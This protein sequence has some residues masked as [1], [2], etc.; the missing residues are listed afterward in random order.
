MN[1][2]ATDYLTNEHQVISAMLGVLEKIAG[3]IKDGQRPPLDDLEKIFD[4]FKTYADAGHHAKEEDILF[5]AL[6]KL[7]VLPGGP[8]CTYFFETVRMRPSAAKMLEC[9]NTEMGLPSEKIVDYSGMLIG[10][11]IQFGNP[12]NPVLEEHLLGRKHMERL[13]FELDQHKKNPN[14]PTKDILF[15]IYSYIDL[16]RSHIEKEDSCL[17]IMVN[18]LLDKNEQERLTEQF[19]KADQRI[20][21]E[22]KEEY[23]RLVNKL[24][25]Q[26]ITNPLKLKVAV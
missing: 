1:F 5:P 16:L 23:V 17:F 11:Q 8:R 24:C 22:Q 20:M 9:M 2:P 7:G 15:Y 19:L 4:F 25:E 14:H 13:F 21:G 10:K 6:Y 26:Y 12:L 3:R 18:N